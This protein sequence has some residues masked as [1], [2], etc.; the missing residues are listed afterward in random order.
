METGSAAYTEGRTL[1]RVEEVMTDL[2]LCELAGTEP[3]F[4]TAVAGHLGISQPFSI[5]SV[6]RSV[7]ESSLGETDVELVLE[8][9]GSRCGLLIENKI[10]ALRMA[11]QIERKLRSPCCLPP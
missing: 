7:H 9:G 3:Q 8:N 1:N 11:R 5:K 6:R 2:I 4:I 10:R